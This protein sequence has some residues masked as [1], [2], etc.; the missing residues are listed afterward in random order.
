MVKKIEIEDMRFCIRG[1]GRINENCPIDLK[2]YAE[3]CIMVMPK[4]NARLFTER[5][6][7]E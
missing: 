3:H 5:S 7:Y 4:C 2:E 6:L 1:L